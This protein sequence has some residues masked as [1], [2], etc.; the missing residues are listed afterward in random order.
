MFIYLSIS[1]L[2]SI[3]IVVL[4]KNIQLKTKYDN[5]K[6][7]IDTFDGILCFKDVNGKILECNS[8]FK[9]IFDGCGKIIGSNNDDFIKYNPQRVTEILQ[10]KNSDNEVSMLKKEIRINEN[11]CVKGE[12]CTFDVR[13]K[14]IFRNGK[15]VGIAIVGKNITDKLKMENFKKIAAEHERALTAIKNSKEIKLQLFANLS[16]EFKTPINVIQSAIATQKKFLENGNLS[17]EEAL[18]HTNYM[19]KNVNRL[20]RIVNNFITI[21]EFE[22]THIN[23]NLI[24]VDIIRLIEDIIASVEISK[25]EKDL[26]IIFDTNTEELIIAIDIDMFE[27]VI[28]NL[29]SNAIKFAGNKKTLLI[30]VEKNEN[31]IAIYAKDNG[32]GICESKKQ[33]IFEKFIQGDMSSTRSNEGSG[34]GLTVAKALIELHSGN[35]TLEK[36]KQGTCFKILLKRIKIGEEVIN[37]SNREEHY[38]QII[39]VELSDI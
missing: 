17:V 32:E 36:S 10:C 16:H 31:D 14:P 38:K 34:I 39:K 13:K 20:T 23:C 27:K 2:I 6:C 12:N 11:F 24:N 4:V 26:E 1:I 15:F 19:E 9:E 28:L 8:D 29:I 30:Y 33:Y 37:L 21:A 18:K 3:V 7:I 22:S 25:I 35:L 5:V